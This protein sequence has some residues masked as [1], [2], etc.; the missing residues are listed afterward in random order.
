MTQAAHLGLCRL[1]VLHLH[2][3]GRSSLAKPGPGHL[4]LDK[5]P[6][7]AC[8]L[9]CCDRLLQGALLLLLLLRHRWSC[10]PC[11]HLLQPGWRP[12]ILL[13][14]ACRSGQPTS[15]TTPS[16]FSKIVRVRQCYE[17]SQGRQ[18]HCWVKRGGTLL[19]ALD[20]RGAQ[21]GGLLGVGAARTGG[22]GAEPE[23]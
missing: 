20:V 5:E 6:Y 1:G 12:P 7:L 14:C 16:R 19:M 10:G 23:G 9:G 11:R 15:A 21:P 3:G 22:A 18:G 17:G 8:L 4:R 13:P 2:I